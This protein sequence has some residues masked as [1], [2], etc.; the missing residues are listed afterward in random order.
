LLLAGL[1]TLDGREGTS[2]MGLLGEVAVCWS[3]LGCLNWSA[4]TVGRELNLGLCT[5]VSFFKRA[6]ESLE[7]SCHERFGDDQLVDMGAEGG[8]RALGIGSD[9]PSKTAAL[10]S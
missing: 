7:V 6:L 8:V 4:L 1:R 9:S 2:D 10:V 5:T 3:S